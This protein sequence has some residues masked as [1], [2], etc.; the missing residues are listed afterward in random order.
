L[1]EL[2]DP[3]DDL[4]LIRR[5]SGRM[6]ALYNGLACAKANGCQNGDDGN[7]NEKL[8]QRESRLLAPP[9]DG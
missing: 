4:P 3:H 5:A 9:C 2:Q 8:D 6:T 1:S 7:D